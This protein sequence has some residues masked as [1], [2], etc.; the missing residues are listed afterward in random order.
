MFMR[1]MAV[2][3]NIYGGHAVA[4]I[5]V[6]F[7]LLL[8][9]VVLTSGKFWCMRWFNWYRLMGLGLARFSQNSYTGSE[10]CE[11]FVCARIEN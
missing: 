9:P 11:H 7:D 10:I 8:Q 4:P 3:G 5:I 6:Q 1:F 2:P